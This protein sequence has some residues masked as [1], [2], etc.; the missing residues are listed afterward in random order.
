MAHTDNT[1]PRR[2]RHP[3]RRYSR[4]W[5]S[6]A[7]L[8]LLRREYNRQ[9]RHNARTDLRRGEQPEPVQPR[10]RALWDAW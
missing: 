9:D 6:S 1:Q 10:H 7:E 8:Q 3:L 4:E 5:V 2:L